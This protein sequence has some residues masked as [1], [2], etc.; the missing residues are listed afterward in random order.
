MHTIWVTNDTIKL[1]TVENGRFYAVAHRNDLLELLSDN[2]VLAN[3][4]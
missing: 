2:E 1:K 3:Q 4:V